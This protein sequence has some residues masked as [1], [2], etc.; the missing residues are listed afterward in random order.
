MTDPVTFYGLSQNADGSTNDIT[1]TREL[2]IPWNT[3]K[4]FN[5]KDP[6]DST[7]NT[8][9]NIPYTPTTDQVASA[10]QS[11]I[12]QKRSNQ[13]SLLQQYVTNAQTRQQVLSNT[14]DAQTS[15]QSQSQ[16]G[17]SQAAEVLNTAIGQMSDILTSIFQ[18]AR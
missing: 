4:T 2:T 17:L 18:V 12:S 9:L 14:Q 11:N 16:T 5:P 7:G 10:I 6:N 13:N 15:I 1:A 3:N 8:S